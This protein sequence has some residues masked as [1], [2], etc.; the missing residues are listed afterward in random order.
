MRERRRFSTPSTTS[1]TGEGT[2]TS[3][4]TAVRWDI[5]ADVKNRGQDAGYTR[6]VVRIERDR[7]PH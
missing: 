3:A 7:R 6:A 5:T 4:C 2:R 1:Y